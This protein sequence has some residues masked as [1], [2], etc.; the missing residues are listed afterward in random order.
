MREVARGVPD[1]A[2]GKPLLETARARR[3]QGQRA[4]E[5]KEFRL[6]PLGAGSDYGAFLHHTGI[7]SS[8]A[9]FSN[10]EAG[11]V[12]HSIY[13]SLHWFTNFSDKDL[14]YGRTLA[15]FMTASILRMS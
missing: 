13:D 3:V 14:S 1:P 11:G 4:A 9:G 15:Q 5:E 6:G 10:V 2:A 7:Q 12:Y 8:T